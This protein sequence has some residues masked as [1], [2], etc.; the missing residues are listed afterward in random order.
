LAKKKIG[1]KIKTERFIYHYQVTTSMGH[2]YVKYVIGDPVIPVELT[3]LIK[4]GWS[5][6]KD[7]VG[8]LFY[9]SGIGRGFTWS[10][11]DDPKGSRYQ[12]FLQNSDSQEMLS[13]GGVVRQEY[14]TDY[15]SIFRASSEANLPIQVILGVQSGFNEIMA[16][17]MG[18][19]RTGGIQIPDSW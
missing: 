8:K 5:E 9:V 16:L 17:K 7:R 10:R 4:E 18:K 11:E 19:H 3:E 13:L 1:A 12:A 2:E 14:A 6:R 15:E